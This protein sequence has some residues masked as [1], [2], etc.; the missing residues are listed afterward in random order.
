[1]LLQCQLQGS[2]LGCHLTE[3]CEQAFGQHYELVKKLKEISNGV[4]QCWRSFGAVLLEGI[5]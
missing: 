4:G 1:M 5:G 3:C 2:Q